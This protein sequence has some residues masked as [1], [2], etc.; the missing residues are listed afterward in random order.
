MVPASICMAVRAHGLYR[1]LSCLTMIMLMAALPMAASSRLFPRRGVSALRPGESSRVRPMTP[2]MVT[3]RPR[4]K[5]RL[6]FSLRKNQAPAVTKRGTRA[7]MIPAW[8][9]VVKVRA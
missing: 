6:T 1:A 7:E 5:L 3:P 9:E 4:A 8:D 2:V